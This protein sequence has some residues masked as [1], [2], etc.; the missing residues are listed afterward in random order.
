MGLYGTLLSTPR[1][2]VRRRGHVRNGSNAALSAVLPRAPRGA[3]GSDGGTQAALG[4]TCAGDLTP[5]GS[6]G[7]VSISFVYRQEDQRLRL[8]SCADAIADPIPDCSAN[9]HADRQ[10]CAHSPVKHAVGSAAH[11]SQCC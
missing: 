4:G 10:R 7:Y 5:P 11:A 3:V 1:S 6:K 8:C 2:F 9:G